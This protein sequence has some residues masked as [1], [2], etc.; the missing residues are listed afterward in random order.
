[1]LV[2]FGGKNITGTYYTEQLREW[3][4]CIR[5]KPRD[6]RTLGAV[7]LHH[8][9]RVH[10]DRADQVALQEFSFQQ[11]NNNLP[12]SLDLGSSEYF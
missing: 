5:H 12:Y 1:M 7:L 6:K 9:V 10:K 3:K 8:D 11:L 4:E 2:W